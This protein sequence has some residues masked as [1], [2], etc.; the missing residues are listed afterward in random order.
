M[1]QNIMAFN[2]VWGNTGD[3]KLPRAWVLREDLA[4]QGRSVNDLYTRK[5]REGSHRL[6]PPGL[7]QKRLKSK[8]GVLDV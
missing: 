5:Q 1:I 6:L 8:A 7:C 4:L 2:S 3:W